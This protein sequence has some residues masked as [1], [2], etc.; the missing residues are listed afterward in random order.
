MLF[1]DVAETI[2][3]CRFNDLGTDMA[4]RHMLDELLRPEER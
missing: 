1:E 2:Y 3:H 4:G